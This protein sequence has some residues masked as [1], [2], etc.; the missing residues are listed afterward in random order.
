[1]L[2][3]NIISQ[4]DTSVK[5]VWIFIVAVVFGF[6]STRILSIFV[7]YMGRTGK[8]KTNYND[9]ELNKKWVLDIRL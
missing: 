2:Y 6:V 5:K 1:M 8:N 4:G 9:N 3:H 7:L